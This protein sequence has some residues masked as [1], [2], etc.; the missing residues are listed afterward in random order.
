MNMGWIANQPNLADAVK[1]KLARAQ[2]LMRAA[3]DMTRELVEGL[4][5][6]L[7]DN[8][9]LYPALRWHMK[10]SCKAACVTYTESFPLSEA[11]MAPEVRIGVFRIFQETLK[12]VLLQRTPSG[13]S[14]KAEVIGD[15]LHCHLIHHRKATPK[16]QSTSDP[17]KPRCILGPCMLAAICNG[18]ARPPGDTCICRCRYRTRK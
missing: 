15:I 5:P 11:R 10:A 14:V 17:L 18:A 7:L 1:E 9:G 4:K 2:G 8:V 12:E 16:P 6:T 3:I 13:L